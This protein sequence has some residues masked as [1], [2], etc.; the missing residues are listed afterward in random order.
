MILIQN[1][2][3]V[4]CHDDFLRQLLLHLKPLVFYPGNIVVTEGQINNTMYVVHRG[5]VEAYIQGE[6]FVEV[7][8]EE[9]FFG[10]VCG[11]FQFIINAINKKGIRELDT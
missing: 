10:M 4:A 5:S 1:F 9:A 7:L 2:L 3:F 6:T 8:G 11:N